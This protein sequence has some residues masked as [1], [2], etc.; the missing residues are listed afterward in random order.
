MGMA[1]S[2]ETGSDH[3]SSPGFCQGTTLK[4]CPAFPVPEECILMGCHAVF[5][6]HTDP[7]HRTM[8]L[9]E[10]IMS[11]CDTFTTNYECVFLAGCDWVYHSLDTSA[12]L[13][14]LASLDSL[15]SDDSDHL[16][17]S[18]SFA[19]DELSTEAPYGERGQPFDDDAGDFFSSS[20]TASPTASPT[21][22]FSSSTV[23]PTIGIIA[24]A[25][26]GTRLVPCLF[27]LPL[28]LLLF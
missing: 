15:D 20:P 12:F 25:N 11:P 9:C 8:C 7:A 22:S 10:A 3:K 5:P 4:T 1:L 19:D 13:D 28:G 6:P 16:S 24:V 27:F 18:M 2:T 23:P 26:A 14:S 21:T 17:Y